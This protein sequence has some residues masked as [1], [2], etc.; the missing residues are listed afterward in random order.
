MSFTL[1][2]P[3]AQEPITLALARLQCR[4]DGSAEDELLAVYI[5]TARRQAEARTGRSLITQ[6]LDLVLDAFPA[7]DEGIRL[8]RGPVQSVS[9][10]SYVDSLGAPQTLS[11][12]LYL[13]D[14]AAS[15]SGWVLPADG[16][17]WPETDDVVNAVTVRMVCGYG[18]EPAA[19]PDDIRAWMLM[20]I[21]YLYAQREAVDMSGRAAELPCR[22]YDGLLDPYVIYL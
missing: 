5:A 12:A 16:T 20:S 4:V 13:V 21:A 2:T 18:A 10:V 19:V 11:N 6:T 1:I 7:G 14:D 9:S 22:F 8:E 17:S 15:P 3:P